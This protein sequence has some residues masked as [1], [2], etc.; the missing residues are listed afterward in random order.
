MF[1]FFSYVSSYLSGQPDSAG[2]LRLARPVEGH[3]QA[4]PMQAVAVPPPM[5]AG[6]G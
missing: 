5:E 2:L 4:R 1:P 3:P 6:L